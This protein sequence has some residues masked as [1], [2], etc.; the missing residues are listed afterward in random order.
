MPDPEWLDLESPRGR[1][2]RI[3]VRPDTSDAATLHSTFWAPGRILHDEYG[4]VDLH[5]TGWAIDVGAHIGSVAIALA[6]D[7]TDLQ[8]LAI[9]A[10]PENAALL[11][12]NVR[13]ADVAD[14]VHVIAAAAAGPGDRRLTIRYGPRDE[15][16][17]DEDDQSRYIGNLDRGHGR[18]G[19]TASV[20]AVS[21]PGLLSEHHI[22]EVAYAKL[23]CEGCEWRFLATPAVARIRLIGGEYHTIGHEPLLQLLGPTHDV[24]M[25][26]ED[27]GFGLFRATRRD[28]TRP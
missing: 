7:N 27:G 22:E 28:H 18:R 12:E 3:K 26:S 6:L 23:D 10:V 24:E 15:F 2:I 8:V 13:L 17:R 14:R 1:R 25:L 4:L 16:D 19:V 20:P 11:A 9:E 5:L 21:L